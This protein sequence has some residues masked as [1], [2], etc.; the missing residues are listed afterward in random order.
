MH[1]VPVV[2][3][4]ILQKTRMN[5]L[6]TY[7]LSFGHLCSNMAYDLQWYILPPNIF[8]SPFCC[9]S[10]V[11]WKIPCLQHSRKI[12]MNIRKIFP[13]LN[14]E[15]HREN[16]GGQRKDALFFLLSEVP[17]VCQQD[18]ITQEWK[19]E[20]DGLYKPQFSMI[21]CS[22]IKMRSYLRIIHGCL[23]RIKIGPICKTQIHGLHTAKAKMDKDSEIFSGMLP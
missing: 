21:Q 14:T 3:P 6:A 22:P 13:R 18:N 5:F 15:S 16:S 1:P 12:Q 23:G 4:F 20:G 2:S 17:M 8:P 7:F 19:K 10:F 9:S 11:F